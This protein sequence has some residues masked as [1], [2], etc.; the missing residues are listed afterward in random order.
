[1]CGGTP[2]MY[3]PCRSIKGLSPRV[4]GN[5]LVQAAL[6]A[7]LRSIPAC[8]GEPRQRP[9]GSVG[10]PVYPR[11]CGGTAQMGISAV[12]RLGLS[13]RVRGN[14]PF[15]QFCAGLSGSIP[16]CAGEP[17]HR[18]A[19]FGV[20]G[21]YPRVCGGTRRADWWNGP[22]PG[23][24][25]RVRGNPSPDSAA[26]GSVRSIPACA[27]EPAPPAPSPIAP[28]VY[29]RV[30]GGTPRQYCHME[31]SCG[32]SPRVRGNREIFAPNNRRHGSIPA[33]AGEPPIRSECEPGSSI[34][35]RVCGG[36]RRIKEDILLVGNLSPRVRGNLV[37][38]M[39]GEDDVQSI[40]ACAGEPPCCT[41]PIRPAKVYPRVCG[42]TGQ[43]PAH[44]PPS[45][46]LS[47]RVR[48][49]PRWYGNRGYCRWSIPACAGEPT[50]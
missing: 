12:R 47:P 30:C 15:R 34:Y 9:V 38:V 14:L 42:G 33:C 1:M 19:A 40:P 22:A 7:A 35:P 36:T 29:P 10:T 11:V 3:Q 39:A 6:V 44:P 32:L 18:L 37:A 41:S 13:P 49:N 43:S 24:S 27:G 20:A 23:L 46:G 17:H 28:R 31:S 50:P 26:G 8:A 25:P 45:R 48:G 21:V 5:L 4:R 16:A 2:R